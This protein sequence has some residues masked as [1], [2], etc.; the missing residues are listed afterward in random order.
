M[1]VVTW[2]LIYATG[3]IECA[4]ILHA[5]LVANVLRLPMSFFDMTPVGRLLARFSSDIHVVDMTLP[6]NIKAF[7]MN[8]FKV[9]SGTLLLVKYHFAFY[10]CHG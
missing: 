7:A 2:E 8:F 4:I 9:C 10:M 6:H 1:S 3:I 5:H